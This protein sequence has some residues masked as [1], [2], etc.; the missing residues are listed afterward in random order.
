MFQLHSFVHPSRE[1]HPP[2]VMLARPPR[3]Q[4]FIINSSCCRKSPETEKGCLV[5]CSEKLPVNYFLAVVSRRTT[6]PT[7]L[8]PQLHRGC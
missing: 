2:P 5:L 6:T 7:V 4:E 1:I 8:I 3:T